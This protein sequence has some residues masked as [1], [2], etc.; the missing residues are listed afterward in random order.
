M[1]DGKMRGLSI[2]LVLLPALLTTGATAGPGQGAASQSGAPPPTASGAPVQDGSALPDPA[3]LEAFLD[4]LIQGQLRE[5]SIAVLV[6]AAPDP[7]GFLS[8]PMTGF[9]LAL[10]LPVLGLVATGVAGWAAWTQWRQGAGTT[11]TRIRVTTAV[12]VALLFAGSLHYWNLLGWR[13]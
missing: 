11:S 5:R 13:L 3:V 10:A 12:A 2:L 9:A 8:T 4:G 6:M 7:F 1:G